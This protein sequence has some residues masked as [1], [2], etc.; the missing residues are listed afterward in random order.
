ML[1]TNRCG[2]SDPASYIS[3]GRGL[4]S[5]ASL[6]RDGRISVT[7]H[8]NKALPDLPVGYANPVRE[9]AVDPSLAAPIHGPRKGGRVPKLSIVIMIVGSRGKK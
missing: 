7:M 3:S 9:F 8:L 5:K 2:C 6:S 1:Y 4:K